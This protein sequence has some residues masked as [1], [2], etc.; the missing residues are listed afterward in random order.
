LCFLAI[1]NDGLHDSSLQGLPALLILSALTLNKRDLII[2]SVSCFFSLLTLG[3]FQHF[4]STHFQVYNV[5]SDTDIFDLL[6]IN[7]ATIILVLLVSKYLRESPT[8][9]RDG[10]QKL[11]VSEELY[12]RLYENSPAGLYR[13]TLDG[14]FLLANP[15]MVKLM[16]FSS[17]EEFSSRN[18]EK[19]GYARDYDRDHFLELIEKD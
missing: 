2:L 12:R 18:H 1:V 6:I 15:S 7:G 16:G 4:Y 14:R 17:F 10:E 19:E 8:K 5:F 11:K 3:L 9:I 13:T